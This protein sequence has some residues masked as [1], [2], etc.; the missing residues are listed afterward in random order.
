MKWIVNNKTRA[1][2]AATIILGMLA[3]VLP[4]S[5]TLGMNSLIGL[6][7]GTVVW[8]TVTPVKKA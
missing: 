6:L 4:D 2:G 7:M 5:V 3:P 1:A 8:N